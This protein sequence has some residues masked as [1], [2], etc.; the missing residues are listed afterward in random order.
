MLLTALLLLTAQQAAPNCR[1]RTGCDA[2]MAAV[3][4]G[5]D[6]DRDG[7]VSRAEWD[8]MGDTMLAR[9]SPPATPD[10][11]AEIRKDIAADFRWEDGNGDGYITREEMLKVR[12]AVFSCMDGNGD[13]TISDAEKAAGEDKCKPF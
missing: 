6:V 9:I 3:I 2:G 12:L 8:R 1:T 11:M 4:D 13:G 10:V 5:W 7:R